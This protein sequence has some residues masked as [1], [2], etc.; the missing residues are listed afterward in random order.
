MKKNVAI[1]VTVVVVAALAVGGYLLLKPAKSKTYT[2]NT[3][4]SSDT[5]KSATTNDSTS[6]K[7]VN[8][9]LVS[10]KTSGNTGQYLVDPS[11][12]PLYTYGADKSSVSN[13]TDSCLT[14]WP[15]YKASTSTDLP[16]DFSTIK[17][18]DTGELQYTYKGMPLY[19]FTSDSANHPTGDNLNDFHL[20]QP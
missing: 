17:R 12:M 3:S 4:T 18:T 7:A 14:T 16:T 8:N 2:S 1:I 9:G 19:Y 5:S 20:A 10:T 6:A 13:C 11:N 15:I